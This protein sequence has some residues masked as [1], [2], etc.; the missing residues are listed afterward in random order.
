MD[1]AEGLGYLASVLVVASSSMKTMTP[2]RVLSIASNFAFISYSLAEGLLPILILHSIL[3]PIN[4]IRL[5]QMQRLLRSVKEAAQGD[6]AL[7]GL[8]PFMTTRRFRQGEI[9]F[10]KNDPSHEMFYLLTGEIH[11]QEI[12]RTIGAGTV[13]GEIAMFSPDKKRTATAICATGGKLLAMSEDQVRRLYFQN[14]KFGFY[15]VQLITRRL[16]ENCA[17]IEAL[18]GRWPDVER[19]RTR[20]AA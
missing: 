19:L 17:T 4:S 11:L 14:P 6:L 1:A 15:L 10:C 13:L 5:F 18:P 16:L 12:G 9:L 2:L 7:K 8:L 20:E 3:L